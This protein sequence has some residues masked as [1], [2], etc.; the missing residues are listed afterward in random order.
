MLFCVARIAKHVKV[1][2]LSISSAMFLD[3]GYYLRKLAVTDGMGEAVI[4]SS[5]IVVMLVAVKCTRPSLGPPFPPM[6]NVTLLVSDWCFGTDG[7]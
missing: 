4:S 1:E 3:I 6:P 5:G 7:Y 2:K